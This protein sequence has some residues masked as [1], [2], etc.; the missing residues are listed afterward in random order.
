MVTFTAK[1]QGACS[2]MTP[3][4]LEAGRLTTI[5]VFVKGDVEKL[6]LTG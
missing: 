6:T 5:R 2:D 1:H 3:P 4:H